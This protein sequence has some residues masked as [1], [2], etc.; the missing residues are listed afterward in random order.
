MIRHTFFDCDRM[1]VHFMVSLGNEGDSSCKRHIQST[2]GQH[3]LRG[4]G[5]ACFVAVS[6]KQIHS[7]SKAQQVPPIKR[8]QH[9][10]NAM[11]MQS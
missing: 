8:T 5:T 1:P 7:F 2:L 11:L 10:K 6:N 3:C 4:I 9:R